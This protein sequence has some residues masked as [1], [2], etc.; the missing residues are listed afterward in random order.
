M[1][2]NKKPRRIKK[3]AGSRKKNPMAKILR[4][5]LFKLKVKSSVKIYSRK[6]LTKKSFSE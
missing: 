4:T 2:V 3:K 5:S 1:D 6:K